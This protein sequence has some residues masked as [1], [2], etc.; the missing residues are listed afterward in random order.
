MCI[1]AHIYHW[2]SHQHR[3]S[4]YSPYDYFGEIGLLI[5]ALQDDASSIPVR[6]NLI[7]P[8]VSGTWTPE[9]VWNTGFLNSYSTSLGYLAVEQ[10]PDNNCYAQYGIGSPKDP[11]TELAYYLNHTA[12]Q[13]IVKPF[14]NSTT[15]AQQ[16]NKPFLMFETN[17]ASCGGFPGISNSFAST[18]WVLDYGLQMGYSNFSGAL[19]HVGGQSV[20]YNVSQSCAYL[21]CQANGEF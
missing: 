8:S 1:S 3:P 20:Y 2:H 13:L 7:A 19:L 10:Y 21:Q 14:L 12:G 16:Y 9:D 6:N 17:T 18:L 11:Q 15:I 5:Q 4:T